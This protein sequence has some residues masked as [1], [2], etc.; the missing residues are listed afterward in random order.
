MSVSRG[1]SDGSMFKL[2]RGWSV[3]TCAW[4]DWRLASIGGHQDHL[5]GILLCS[6]AVKSIL[7]RWALF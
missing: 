3:G 7:D 1:S 6:L 4:R 2:F 5:S